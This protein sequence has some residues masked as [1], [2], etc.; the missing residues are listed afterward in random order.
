VVV[1]AVE[2]WAPVGTYIRRM[3]MVRHSGDSQ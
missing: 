1:R 3:A 2:S